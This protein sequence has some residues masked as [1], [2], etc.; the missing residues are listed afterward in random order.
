[1]TL[2]IEEKELNKLPITLDAR[3][4]ERQRRVLWNTRAG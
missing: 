1:M 2:I 4:R 3:Y